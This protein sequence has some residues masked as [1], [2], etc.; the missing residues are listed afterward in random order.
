MMTLLIE[1]YLPDLYSFFQKNQFELTVN[2]FIHKWL[3]CLF[4]QNFNLNLS[5][6]ILDFFFLEGYIIII[7]TCLG[8]F[9]ILR[10]QLMAHNDF[11]EVYQVL[12][13]KTNDIKNPLLFLYFIARR[14]FEFNI[15]KIGYFQDILQIPIIENLRREKV[16]RGLANLNYQPII[17]KTKKKPQCDPNWPFC[18]KENINSDI[19][20]VLVLNFHRTPYIIDD[21]YYT[22]TFSYPSE[23][24]A[25]IDEYFASGNSDLLLERQKHRCDDRKLVES[26]IIMLDGKK[27]HSSNDVRPQV[28]TE[29]VSL[30]EIAKKGEGFEK[31]KGKI[32]NELIASPIYE[33]EIKEYL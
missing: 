14:K 33:N 28:N 25:L 24:E 5:D 6:I 9:A 10:K 21:Y 13:E 17:K 3:V 18:L 7:K 12:N 2:N 16:K 31:A 4:A 22:K 8:V 26:S 27:A 11:E 19:L 30:Y 15:R 23:K 1:K 29:R 32:M 20:Q